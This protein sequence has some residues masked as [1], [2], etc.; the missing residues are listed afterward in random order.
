[1]PLT[2]ATNTRTTMKMKTE[3][4][5]KV[6]TTPKLCSRRPSRSSASASSC[7]RRRRYTFTCLPENCCSCPSTPSTTPATTPSPTPTPRRRQRRSGTANCLSNRASTIAPRPPATRLQ[8][9][10]TS[11]SSSTPPPKP[12]LTTARY[13]LRQRE[14]PILGIIF[15]FFLHGKV[16]GPL[17]TPPS[18]GP[19]EGKD[20]LRLICCSNPTLRFDAPC[21]NECRFCDSSWNSCQTLGARIDPR[22]C[23]QCFQANQAGPR[24]STS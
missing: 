14:T 12:T 1:M 4:K 9:T 6:T 15:P 23:S 21:F 8:E 22:A 20:S 13:R 3:V 17:R 2:T 11:S 19:V 18:T 16:R 10:T 5:M 24:L 7:R